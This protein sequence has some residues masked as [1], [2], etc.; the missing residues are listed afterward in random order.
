VSSALTP[1]LE[2]PRRPPGTLSYHELQGFLFAVASSPDLIAPSEWMP[3]VFGDHE[4]EYE[5]LDEAQHV[6]GELMSVYNDINA[7][8]VSGAAALP[9][10]CVVFEDGLANLE[11]HAPVSLWSRGFLRGH[12]WLEESWDPYIVDELEDDYAVLLMTLSFFASSSLA[13]EFCEE[14]R[15]PSLPEMASTL[16]QA[17]PQAVEEYAQLGLWIRQAIA[18]AEHHEPETRESPKI[19]RNEPCPCGSGR[20]YKKCCGAM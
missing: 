11:D 15:H 17:F 4:I 1:F 13:R 20:K 18:E 12:Q 5:S 6:I 3:F 8:V 14:A 9:A 10:D 7:S 2:D 19:G 16:A